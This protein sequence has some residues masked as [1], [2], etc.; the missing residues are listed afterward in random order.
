[1]YEGEL[2]TLSHEPADLQ[3][4]NSCAGLLDLALNSDQDAT[5]AWAHSASRKKILI[6]FINDLPI[7]MMNLDRSL[8]DTGKH[9]AISKN[10]CLND[11]LALLNQGFS[12]A[13]DSK[14]PTYLLLKVIKDTLEGNLSFSNKALSRYILSQQRPIASTEYLSLFKLTTKKEQE[15]LSLVCMGLSNNEVAERLSVSI[16]TIKMH[17]QNIY[18]KTKVK[19][20]SQLLLAYSR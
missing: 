1:M 19:N 9:I 13:C 17:L 12:G 4:L 10:L 14:Q 3:L 20:R 8:F 11:E 7:A 15:V 5:F 6:H 16:N 18:K 2:F